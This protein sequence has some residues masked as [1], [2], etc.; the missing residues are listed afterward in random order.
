MKATELIIGSLIEY[1]GAVCKVIGISED[2][3]KV[4][5]Y[6]YDEDMDVRCDKIQGIPLT[7]DILD[8]TF[9]CSKEFDLGAEDFAKW[10]A[11]E[12]DYSTIS[13]LYNLEYCIFTL[14]TDTDVEYTELE[15]V[16]QLQQWLNILEI[17]K[18]VI[19]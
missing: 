7:T 17:K 8:K 19:L 18:E 9:G 3:I 4:D 16:H 14:T 6:F 1:S 10:D 11:E 12:S 13:I 15:Y 2:V 5:N